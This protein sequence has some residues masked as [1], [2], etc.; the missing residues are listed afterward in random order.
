[1]GADTV[2]YYG[3]FKDE[4]SRYGDIRDTLIKGFK[5]LGLSPDEYPLV[6]ENLFEIREGYLELYIGNCY[7]NWGNVLKYI[8]SDF[9]KEF[10]D[11]IVEFAVV[12]YDNGVYV[13]KVI[14]DGH[15]LVK[16]KGSPYEEV[17]CDSNNPYIVN[18][19]CPACGN[20]TLE[21]A[22]ECTLYCLECDAEFEEGN[23]DDIDIESLYY[24]AVEEADGYFEYEFEYS[25]IK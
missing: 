21:V 23:F 4:K 19:E 18:I 16:D 13:E 20:S 24:K 10:S 9:I 5:K 6:W 11:I 2:K 15:K 3:R 7:G 14:Y 25:F 12:V 22:D 1:M 8:E 17:D